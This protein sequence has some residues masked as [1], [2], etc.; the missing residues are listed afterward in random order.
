MHIRSIWTV[1]FV[2]A[3]VCSLHGDDDVTGRGKAA[4]TLHVGDLVES[5]SFE[6]LLLAPDGANE[7]LKDLKGK[8]VVLD[9]WSTT[10]AP[11]IA[12]FPHLK[13]LA[14][15][16]QNELVTFVAVTYEAREVVEK[17]L[18]KRSVPVWV[19]LDTDESEI[20][21]F[22]IRSV[23]TTIVI[24]AEGRIQSY[25]HTSELTEEFLRDVISGRLPVK[26]ASRKM[27]S[28]SD[29]LTPE[30]IVALSQNFDA[31]D[32]AQIVFR[33][34]KFPDAARVS[35]A[36][37]LPTTHSLTWINSK[38]SDVAPWAFNIHSPHRLRYS[39]DCGEQMVDL[40]ATVPPYVKF[41]PETL[42]RFVEH[43]ISML[44]LKTNLESSKLPVYILKSVDSSKRTP[45]IVKGGQISAA[46][47]ELIVLNGSVCALSEVLERILDRPVI[48]ESGAEG[49]FDF[50]L[51]WNDGDLQSLRDALR[52]ESGLVLQ[53][54]ERQVEVLELSFQAPLNSNGQAKP[55]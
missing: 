26:L 10:C 18:A 27:E 37:I 53:P 46:P 14:E 52:D 5:L 35:P 19:A 43:S 15:A 51:S 12:S 13:T 11:C 29:E 3:G 55:E 9:F 23:P 47:G 54:A 20:N 44:G 1:L 7:N 45:S 31:E 2:L 42:R 33:R 6:E 41:P 30:A 28:P 25:T 39:V 17:F 40:V 16:L 48:D 50:E 34:T 32:G 49:R 36:M 8:V 38:L 4:P 24:D 22:G 21:R